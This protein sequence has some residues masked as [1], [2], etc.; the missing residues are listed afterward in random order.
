M[1]ARKVKAV[2]AVVVEEPKPFD[3]IEI[4]RKYMLETPRGDELSRFGTVVEKG[5]LM[6][7]HFTGCHAELS[8]STRM[9]AKPLALWSYVP[10]PSHDLDKEAFKAW[11]DYLVHRSPWKQ[12]VIAD[13]TTDFVMERGV[14]CPTNVPANFLA[15]LLIATRMPREHASH[16]TKWHELVKAGAQ[17]DMAVIFACMMGAGLKIGEHCGN[18]HHPFDHFDIDMVTNFVNHRY[19]RP[20]KNYIDEKIYH[21]SSG[22]WGTA[23]S[24]PGAWDHAY[25]RDVNKAYFKVLRKLYAGEKEGTNRMFVVAAADK[26]IEHTFKEWVEIINKEHERLCDVKEAQ[27][28]AAGDGGEKAAVGVRKRPG[29]R[30]RILAHAPRRVRPRKVA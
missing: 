2:A 30:G 4:A 22:G 3:A 29:R 27:A 25:Q 17:E 14:I 21:P 9:G 20:N 12:V 6:K 10:T 1:V 13:L 23:T 7:N 19:A 11:C 18:G 26:A 16:V 24:K 28:Q 5:K 15:N 8:D